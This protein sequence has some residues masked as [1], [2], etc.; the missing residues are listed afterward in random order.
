MKGHEIRIRF[1]PAVF[2]ASFL[3][4]SVS[5][6]SIGYLSMRIFTLVQRNTGKKPSAI[7]PFQKDT[8]SRPESDLPGF[9]EPKANTVNEITPEWLGKKVEHHINSDGLRDNREYEKDKPE[10]VFRIA[11]MGDSFTYGLFVGDDD[12]YPKQLEVLANTC[13][14]DKKIEVINFGV[15][16]YDLEMSAYRY[17]FRIK[18]YTPDLIVWYLI[19]ND[20]DE[21]NSLVQ[22]LWVNIKEMLIAE[23]IPYERFAPETAEILESVITGRLGDSFIPDHQ[24]G[25]LREWAKGVDIPFVI[26]TDSKL[27]KRYHDAVAGVIA[28]YPNGKYLDT[29]RYDNAFSEGHPSP[30]SHAIIAKSIISYLRK[31]SLLP[32]S[33]R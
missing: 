14:A 17:D 7:I 6:I 23:N 8:L 15:P 20:F 25:K 13:G 4:V 1:S 10:N 31:E 27:P 26:V 11:V 28:E 32:C 19:E 29:I 22:D 5:F 33:L 24:I 21:Y 9:Y 3:F 18:D 2:I 30:A 16:G 12:P